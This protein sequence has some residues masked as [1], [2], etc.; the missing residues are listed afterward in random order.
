[1]IA[2][3]HGIP[4]PDWF[5]VD[6]ETGLEPGNEFFTA[7]F[8][9]AGFAVDIPCQLH[10]DTTWENHNLHGRFTN[11][12]RFAERSTGAFVAISASRLPRDASSADW[13]WIEFQQTDRKIL[14]NRTVYT[15]TGW[16]L[17]ALA[18]HQT[19]D[20][21][22]VSRNGV[23]KDGDVVF[24]I[25]AGASEAAYPSMAQ[26]LWQS[27]R[28]LRLLSPTGKRSA[29]NLAEFTLT[30]QFPIAFQ[31]PVSWELT[32][33]EVGETDFLLDLHNRVK[34]QSVGRITIAGELGP[35]ATAAARLTQTYQDRLSQCDL[36]VPQLEFH[37]TAGTADGP[38]FPVANTRGQS[39]GRVFDVG[40]LLFP[41]HRGC[42][43]LGNLSPTIS[44]APEW[45]AINRRAFEIVRDSVI[46]SQPL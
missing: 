25:E 8:A 31:Y 32:Q 36:R 5:P 13:L 19:S 35:S 18:S 1:M 33:T 34:E 24:W 39:D 11:L 43:L 7:R 27:V 37:V 28:S 3:P 40:A 30:H 2:A 21:R 10:H 41:T 44:E 17:D 4:D 9:D 46:A 12:T 20:G 42:L 16:D 14:A 22:T 15:A 26:L 38:A 29:E 6:A 45:W 23:L